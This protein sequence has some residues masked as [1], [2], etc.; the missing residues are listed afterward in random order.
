MI[1]TEYISFNVI[2]DNIVVFGNVSCPVVRRSWCAYL[3]GRCFS[4]IHVH[5][6]HV[7][8][9][10]NTTGIV[11]VLTCTGND[12]LSTLCS[13]LLQ[14]VNHS[15]SIFT[16][17]KVTGKSCSGRMR[18]RPYITTVKSV[19]LPQ[20]SMWIWRNWRHFQSGFGGQEKYWDLQL[21]QGVFS[22]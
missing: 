17:S 7:L 18:E 8:K 3:Y 16:L 15:L 20:R 21:D 22:C 4:L 14:C 6:G 13:I 12:C 19:L 2:W 10:R 11:M 5:H 1:D 9:W